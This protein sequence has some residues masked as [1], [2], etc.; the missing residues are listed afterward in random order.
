ML[1]FRIFS[2]SVATVL[3]LRPQLQPTIEPRNRIDVEERRKSTSGRR[4][5]VVLLVLVCM[6]MRLLAVSRFGSS[7]PPTSLC[8][9]W[10]TV[11][12]DDDT[13]RLMVVHGGACG[14]DADHVSVAPF[15]ISAFQ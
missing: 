3:Q 15:S 13:G 9:T 6:C 4:R 5:R 2:L 8:I 12:I 10:R 1:A 7:P 11:A 14:V